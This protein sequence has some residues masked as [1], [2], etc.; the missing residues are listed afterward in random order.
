MHSLDNAI[1]AVDAVNHLIDNAA[2]N[3]HVVKTPAEEA[4][5]RE[6]KAELAQKIFNPYVGYGLLRII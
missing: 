1:T 5:A 2:E 6:A 4:Q 3:G